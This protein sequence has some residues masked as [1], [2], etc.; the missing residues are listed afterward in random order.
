M[1]VA[2][3]KLMMMPLF[4]WSALGSLVLIIFAFP[5]LTATLSMLALD[6]TMGMHFFTSAFGGNPMMYV[7]LIW[8]WGSEV[9]I[10][11]L[12]AFGVFSESRSERFRANGCS[13]TNRWFGPSSPS[14]FC[15][16]LS[17][18]ITSLR[19]GQ[20]ECQRLLWAL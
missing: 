11:I 19:W 5:I 9:Y 1:R 18:C 3:M 12:P 17:G 2:G 6:R 16:L 20:A 13:A 8:A 4:V 15:H 14:P 7:N 10:L